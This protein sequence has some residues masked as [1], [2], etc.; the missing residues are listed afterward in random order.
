MNTSQGKAIYKY[1]KENYYKVS[2]RFPI[3]YKEKISA[4][5]AAA[6]IS[7]NNFIVS[8]ALEKIGETYTPENLIERK[9]AEKAA[10]K[11]SENNA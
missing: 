4:A 7:V 8:A 2:A 11:Q 5:A 10:R 3:V 1:E 9:K 6:G